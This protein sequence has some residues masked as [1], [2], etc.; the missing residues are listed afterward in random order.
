GGDCG[1]GIQVRSPSCM[2]HNGSVSHPPI[3]VEDSLCG[4]MPFQDSILKQPCSVPCP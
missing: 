1:E 2:V 3:H 4:E